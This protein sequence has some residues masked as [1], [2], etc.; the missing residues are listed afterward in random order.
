MPI[1]SVFPPAGVKED[2]QYFSVR[3]KDTTIESNT[4][5]GYKYTRPRSARRPRRVIKTGFTMLSLAQEQNVQRF[6]ATVGK[7]TMFTYILPT[8][9][10]SLT[11][12]FSAD[13][14]ESKYVGVGGY[15]K[16]NITDIEMTEV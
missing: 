2:S 8:T 4:E 15:H 5:G 14:P 11:V 7:H 16:F 6:M 1:S 13:L 9:G 10:E 3:S 12:R